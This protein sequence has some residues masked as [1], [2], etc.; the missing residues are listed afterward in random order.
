M[1]NAE[2]AVNG[3][4]WAG[5]VQFAFGEPGFR[6]AF[7]AATGLTFPKPATTPIDALVDNACGVHNAVLAKF[8]EWV[9]REHWGIEYAPKAY[10]DELEAQRG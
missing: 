5:F 3:I 7:T 6:E 8:V 10:R 9:T 4:M 1:D 2:D